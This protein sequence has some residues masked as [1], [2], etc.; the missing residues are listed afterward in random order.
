M[1]SQSVTYWR[2]IL[3]GAGGLFDLGNVH[4]IGS[5]DVF[6]A[7]EYRAWLDELG[8]ADKGYWITEAL[9]GVSSQP[10][11]PQLGEDEL[12][13]LT[14]ASYAT[15]FGHGAEVV[16]WVGG[17]DPSGGPGEASERTFLLLAN[18]IGDFTAATLL[19]ENGVRFDMPDGR[20]V[21]ALWDGATLP[22]EVTGTVKAL[23][24][25]G[26]EAHHD[27]AGNLLSREIGIEAE[28]YLPLVLRR[29]RP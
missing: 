5:S 14:L 10:G 11:A 12:A 13:R 4:S 23:T 6:F 28:V 16:I 25:A 21:Y 1:Q 24:Y 26:E 27:A 8:Y 9:V 15:A 20:V 19:T 17:H 22:P 29:Y 18:T 3:E 2:P 7:P